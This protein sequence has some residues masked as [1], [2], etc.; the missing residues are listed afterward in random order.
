MCVQE[1]PNG[2]L[3]QSLLTA[4][5]VYLL[6]CGAEVFLWTGK[7]ST[8]LVRA[9]GHKLLTEL[10]NMIVRPTHSRVHRCIEAREPMVCS[11]L[12]L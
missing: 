1:L 9:A 12:H 8:R 10:H 3:T 11:L 4:K 6:D 2:R 7:A 5:G